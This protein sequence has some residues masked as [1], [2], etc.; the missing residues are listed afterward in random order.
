MG[1]SAVPAPDDKMPA[2]DGQVVRASEMAVPAFGRLDKLPEVITANL[3]ERSFFTDV[4]DPGDGGRVLGD[5][6]E[7]RRVVQLLQ[8]SSE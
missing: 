3:R 2:A 5:G 6:C 7:Q 1:K 8:P 4:L